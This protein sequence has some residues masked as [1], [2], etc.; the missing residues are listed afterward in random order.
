[1]DDWTK[2]TEGLNAKIKQLDTVLN[3]QRSKLAGLKAEYDKVVKSQGE[4]SEAARKLKVQINNQQSVVNRTEKELSNYKETLKSVKEGSIDLEKTSLRAGKA[5]EKTGKQ[6]EEAANG[7]TIAKGAIAGFIANGLTALVGAAKNA[8]SSI[9]GLA[10]ATR[11]YRSTLATLETAATDVGVSTDFIKDKFADLMGVFDDEG[12]IT[13]GL[14]NLLTAGFDESSLDNITKSLEGAA[15]KWKDTLKFEGLADSLQEWIGSGGANLTGNFAELLERMG[16]NLEEVQAKTAGMTDEQRRNY[17][18]NLLNSEG[19][20]KVSQS[21]RDQNKDLV[22]AKEANIEWQN[23]LA[24]AGT[25]I[26]PITTKIREGFTRILEK[27]LELSE[28]VDFEALGAKITEAFDTFINEIMPKIVEGLQW[29]I[30]N[31]D[32]IIAGIAGIGAAFVAW[33]VVGII[34]SVV[35]ALKSMTLAQYALNLAMSLNP[36]GLIIAAIAGLVAAFVVLW[37][38]SEAFRNFWIGLWE[39]IK[40]AF[41]AVVEWIKNNWKSLML[42]IVNPVAGVIK[43]LYDNFDGFREFVDD[44]IKK[45]KNIFKNGWE[46]IKNTFSGVKAFF[47]SKVDE[48]KSAFEG[49]KEKFLDTGENIVKGIWEGIKNGATWLKDKITGFAGDV[50]GWFKKTFKIGSPSKLMAD[51]VGIYVGEGIGEGVLDS[52]PYVK[53]NLSK[54]SGF[55]SDNLGGI[56]SGLDLN[57]TYTGN[58]K[59]GGVS[60]VINAGMTVNYNGSL[61][62]KQ[63]KQLENDNYNTI[64][65]K[66]KNEGVI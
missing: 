64:K 47:K 32:G 9:L 8:V 37:N 61:S 35:S 40:N 63:L 29:I 48:I 14:N 45:V 49:I 39:G 4:N 18:M 55:V 2:S 51:E 16:Y 1:M 30:D 3:L 11:E 60:Q 27:I 58:G 66:L 59:A 56:K 52:I 22:E 15:L 26:E 28:G 19:L 31:K 25:I 53:K 50:S 46:G 36:I 65:M 41:G 62:R 6:A 54:F 57:N 43:Y 34:Q 44:L 21:Y 10:E 23:K 24:E 42:F 12:S 13:E 33:K 38:K 17:A 20:D 5:V 7:F